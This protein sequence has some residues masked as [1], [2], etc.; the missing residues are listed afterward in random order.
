MQEKSNRT[1]RNQGMADNNRRR[2]V[3]IGVVVLVPGF[4]CW[5]SFVGPPG[6]TAFSAA[7]VPA[8]GRFSNGDSLGLRMVN[9]VKP[10]SALH[11]AIVGP[12][13]QRLLIFG[14][15]DTGTTVSWDDRYCNIGRLGV[16]AEGLY[17]IAPTR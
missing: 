4:H 8:L 17:F 13:S 9:S 1:A 16:F 12:V 15:P 5:G 11:G 7:C 2:R 10:W 14:Q 6:Q 3:L